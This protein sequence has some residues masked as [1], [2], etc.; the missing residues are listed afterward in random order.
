MGEAGDDGEEGKKEKEKKK[1]KK[2]NQPI[3]SL[4]NRLINKTLLKQGNH[5]IKQPKQAMLKDLKHLI[6]LMLFKS[7]NILLLLLLLLLLLY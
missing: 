3:T 2:G 4:N 1:K 7:S 6:S 5:Q